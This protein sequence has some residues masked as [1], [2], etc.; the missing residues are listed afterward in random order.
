MV[1]SS[2]SFNQVGG[3]G[4]IKDLDFSKPEKFERTFAYFT[5]ILNPSVVYF[6]RRMGASKTIHWSKPLFL[7]F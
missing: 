6:D 7:G 5:S 3:G 2:E 4:G 1:K